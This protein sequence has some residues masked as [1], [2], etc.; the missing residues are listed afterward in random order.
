M[1]HYVDRQGNYL[2]KH[3][4]AALRTDES[5]TTVRHFLGENARVRLEWTGGPFEPVAGV[6]TLLPFTLKIAELHPDPKRP[7]IKTEKIVDESRFGAEQEAV[8]AYEHYLV[9]HQ[10]CEWLDGD[11]G[12]CFLERGN[13]II[14]SPDAPRVSMDEVVP[15]EFGSW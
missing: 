4:W 5:Y 6:L 10:G 11:S 12:P 14:D 2:L 8:N 13:L 3:E 7:H 1:A 9:M 15:E